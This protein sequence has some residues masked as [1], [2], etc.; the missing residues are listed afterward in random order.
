MLRRRLYWATESD[1]YNKMV[2]TTMRRNEFEEI[3][4]FFHG[5]NN[6]NLLTEDKLAEVWPFLNILNRKC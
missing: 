1:T 2:V 4:K 3:M 6:A 5:A